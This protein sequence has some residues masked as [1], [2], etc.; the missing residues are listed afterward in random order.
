MHENDPPPNVDEMRKYCTQVEV[1]IKPSSPRTKRFKDRLHQI[2][3]LITPS[4][5]MVL[6]V[7][8]D[9]MRKTV[10]KIAQSSNFDIIQFESPYMTQYNPNLDSC[11]TIVSLYAIHS[12]TYRR[13]L[14]S[15]SRFRDKL[16]YATEYLKLPRYERRVCPLFNACLTTSETDASLLRKISPKARI[17]VNENGVDIEY[18]RP[19]LNNEDNKCLVYTGNMSYHPNYDAMLYFHQEIFPLISATEKQVQLYIVGRKPPQQIL[20]LGTLPNVTVTGEVEDIRPYI[21][22]A[23]ICI[24]PLR[25]GSGTRLKILEALAM[26]KAVVSTSVGCEGLDVTHGENII[27]ADEP[28]DFAQWCIEL[29]RNPGLRRKLGQEGRSLVEA[30]YSWKTVCESL[31]Q[32]YQQ[33]W[34]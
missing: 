21:A 28:S 10:E 1:V 16:L 33:L 2:Y 17:F 22:N 8:S 19:V 13:M 27:I 12:V 25:S 26:G 29:L 9:E 4:P 7:S 23:S 3:K 11:K 34:E 30:K 24:V 14:T 15:S 5:R 32:V 6:S 18:F 31:E 20:D